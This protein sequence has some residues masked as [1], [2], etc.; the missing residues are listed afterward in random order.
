MTP[1]RWQQVKELFRSA[2]EQRTEDRAAF[3]E[4]ACDGDDGLRREVESLLASFE[5]SDHFIETPVA[6]AAADLFSGDQSESL[7][8]KRLGHYEVVSL[9]GEGGM[10]E[11]YLAQDTRLNRRVALKVLS[12]ATNSNQE[13][14]QRLWREARAAATLEHQHICAIHEIAEADG[15][16]FIVMQYV[17]GETLASKLKRERMS[18]SEV[19]NIAVQVCA[20][21]EEAHQAHVIHRDIKPANIIVND[22][23][24]AKVLDFGLAKFA[25]ENLEATSKTAT[26]EVLSKSGAIMGT[27]PFMSPEQVRGKRLDARTDIFS[28]GA[29]LY[30]MSCGESAFVRETEAETISAILR[31]QPSWAELPGEL[32]PIVGRSLMKDAGERYQTAKDLLVDLKGL[33][34]RVEME[35]EGSTSEEKFGTPPS[36]GES[37]DARTDMQQARPTSSAEYLVTEISRHK[38]ALAVLV[39]SVL[40]LGL[41]ALYRQRTRPAETSAAATVRSIAVLPLKFVGGQE[42]DETL[43]LGIADTLITRLSSVEQISVRSSG[44]VFKYAGQNADP[45]QAGRALKVDAVLD[46]SIQRQGDR[47]RVFVQLVNVADGAALWTD[48]FDAKIIDFF[49]TQDALSEQIARS[50]TLKLTGTAQ[51]SSVKRYTANAEAYQL[52]LKAHYWWAKGTPEGFQKAIDYYN[53][54]IALDQNNA[55]A[56]AGLADNYSVQASTGL[57]PPHEGLLKAKAA[58][59]KAVQLDDSLISVHGSLG[60]LKWLTWDWAGAEKE[61]QRVVESNP[62]YPPLWYAT[63][64]SSLGRHQEAIAIITKGQEQDPISIHINSCAIRIYHFARQ[65]DEAIAAGLKTIELEPNFSDSNYWLVL[66][67]EQKGMYDEAVA[68][69]LKMMS[70][71]GDSAAEIE[72]LRAAYSASGW[73][74]YWRKEIELNR[75][76]AK[77]KYIPPVEFA[78]MY[79]RVGNK[80]RAFEFLEKA[81]AE[82]SSELAVFKVDPVFDPLRPDSRYA[83]LLRRVGLTP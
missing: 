45:M 49:A 83:N 6:E 77:H 33:Q 72:T 27:V 18:L 5:E 66:A 24:Q 42:R 10:G 54:A 14:N 80:E 56:Y 55:L 59:E 47:V 13:A 63:F 29:M 50:L 79:V 2:L 43:A 58:A 25:A 70:L 9:L 57:V 60:H 53:Q 75:E 71:K 20:A 51:D 40:T 28:F 31:D 39:I 44:A 76:R 11:V 64:L 69:R 1:K 74:G 30:E 32:Q 3:L 23:G 15:F 73:R 65:Y 62:P 81:Y 67:Y 37:S 12:A 16:C 21:L 38:L 82:R 19:L 78:R 68:T 35:T 52:C 41:F 48:K 26:A 36:G 17:E 46:G 8:G 61:F 22:K 7:V 4:R 34:K